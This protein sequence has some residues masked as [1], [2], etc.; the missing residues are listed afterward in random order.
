MIFKNLNSS[1]YFISALTFFDCKNVGHKL[2]LGGTF[3]NLFLFL[4]GHKL[5]PKL[6]FTILQ[7][8][9]FACLKTSCCK[10]FFTV[11]CRYTTILRY[12]PLFCKNKLKQ[13]VVEL[14][15]YGNLGVE[16]YANISWQDFKT[17]TTLCK[18]ESV[19]FVR[20]DIKSSEFS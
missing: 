17:P 8:I 13:S 20:P 6:L 4:I 1:Q 11:R 10:K 16:L 3:W 12:K 14:L 18:I 19:A 7:Q 2:T 9:C 5:S 15:L